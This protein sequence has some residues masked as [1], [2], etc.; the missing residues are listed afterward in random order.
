MPLEKILRLP[1]PQRW[2][3][4]RIFWAGVEGKKTRREPENEE[5]VK[6]EAEK[7]GPKWMAGDIMTGWAEE[8]GYRESLNVERC[9]CFLNIFV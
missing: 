8:R 3:E 9:V 6:V 1:D 2:E 7:R 4:D 5:A